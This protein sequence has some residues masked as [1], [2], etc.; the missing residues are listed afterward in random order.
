MSYSE[1]RPGH[2]PTR[3]VPRSASTAPASSK[4]SPPEPKLAA[5]AD[6]LEP[7]HKY[8]FFGYF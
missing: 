8:D 6:R 5:V 3:D 1:E 2:R 4:A 7:G